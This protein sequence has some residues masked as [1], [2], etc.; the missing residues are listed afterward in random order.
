MIAKSAID[1]VDGSF[2]RGGKVV[3][4]KV[5]TIRRVPHEARQDNWSRLEIALVQPEAS[6]H[7]LRRTL[8][9]ELASDKLY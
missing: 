1:A 3:A 6:S 5:T 9:S 4:D 7:S 8:S 2:H